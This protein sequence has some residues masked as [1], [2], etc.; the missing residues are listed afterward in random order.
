MH[1]GSQ[2]QAAA[3]VFFKKI[4]IWWALDLRLTAVCKIENEVAS[5]D[6]LESYLL[7]PY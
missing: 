7:P 2:P 3:V 1:G 4:S 5:E 6:R